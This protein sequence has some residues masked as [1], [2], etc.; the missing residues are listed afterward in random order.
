MDSIKSFLVGSDSKLVSCLGTVILLFGLAWLYRLVKSFVGF[1]HRHFFRKAHNFG[2]R[3]GK[4]SWAFVTGANRGIGAEFCKQLSKEHGLNIV[5]VGR[6]K[7][8]LQE[9]GRALPTKSQIVLI[10]F[11]TAER[12]DFERV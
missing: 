2:E 7:K 6:N 8:E 1:I 9:V 3:Y 10:D 12:E 11:S 4:N 5:L